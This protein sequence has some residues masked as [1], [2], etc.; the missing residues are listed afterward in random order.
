MNVDDGLEDIRWIRGLRG[1]K[2]LAASYALLPNPK[3]GL[4]F[5]I[6]ERSR[7][8]VVCFLHTRGQMFLYHTPGRR[9]PRITG[10]VVDTVTRGWVGAR[11]ERA[12]SDFTVQLLVLS[13]D[14]CR[15]LGISP[16]RI[17]HFG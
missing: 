15:G 17:K 10:R 5:A 1:E 8:I 14:V 11:N 9:P 12:R 3:K 7:I 13:I 16:L 2:L 4:F 6:R